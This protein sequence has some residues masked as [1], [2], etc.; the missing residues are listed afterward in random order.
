MAARSIKRVVIAAALSGVA[1]A[2]A[3][4]ADAEPWTKTEAHGGGEV[5]E[6][7]YNHRDSIHDM[8]PYS[9]QGTWCCLVE[10]RPPD[11]VARP[12]TTA[13]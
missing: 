8:P 9:S 3:G 1:L 12:Q 2:S 11:V 10:V 7:G 6:S 13:G 4:Q 5:R